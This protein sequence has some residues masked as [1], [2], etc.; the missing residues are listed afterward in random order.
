MDPGSHGA[1]LDRFLAGRIGR[2]SRARV[3]QI[4]DRGHVRTDRGEPLCRAAQ[5]VRGGEVL[6]LHR[7]APVEPPVVMDYGVLYEDCELLALD[8]PA[9]LPVHPSARYHRNTLTALMRERLGADHPW[10]MAHRLDRETSGVLLFGRRGRGSAVLKRAF[11]ERTVHKTYLAV[12]HGTLADPLRIDLPLGPA[13]G[14]RI[15]IKMGY[16]ALNDGGAPACTEVRPLAQGQFRNG[17]VTLLEAKPRSG[18]QHQIRAHLAEIGHG[19][20]GDKLYGLDEQHF[21]DVTDNGA[22]VSQLEAILGL[23][24]HALH[25]YHVAWT[26][27]QTGVAVDISS[28]WPQ[29]LAAI[30]EFPGLDP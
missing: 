24:R 26:H 5:R 20:V 16:R 6:I 4:I 30:V 15:R 13:V 7:P 11:Q 28:P 12:V 29:E 10:V 17:R 18:R 25:A 8:K 14:S 22:P 2:L 23:S 1:R 27:P 19:V 3:Q 9:G 21:I